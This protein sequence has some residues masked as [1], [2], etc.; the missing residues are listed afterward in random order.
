MKAYIVLVLM[1]ISTAANA[2]CYYNGY[3]YPTGANIGGLT[4]KADGTWK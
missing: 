2:D 1:L 3:L 4:C